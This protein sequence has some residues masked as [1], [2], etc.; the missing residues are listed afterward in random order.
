MSIRSSRGLASALALFALALA[1]SA[2]RASR[3]ADRVRGPG[4]RGRQSRGRRT[5]DGHRPGPPHDRLLEPRGARPTSTATAWSR[6]LTSAPTTATRS[7]SG[8]RATAARPG[9]ATTWRPSRAPIRGKSQGFSDPDLTLD[10]GARIY[11]TGINLANDSLF[12]SKD[13][14]QARSTRAR[15]SVTT[16]IARGWPAGS[17]TRCSWPRNTGESGHAVFRRT[18]T[19][20]T[21]AERHG[22]GRRG[23]PARRHQLHRRRQDLLRP[24]A[25]GKLVE[26]VLFTKGSDLVGGSAWGPRKPGDAKFVPVQAAPLPSGMFAHWPSMAIDAADNLYM[27]WDTNERAPSGAG[28]CGSLPPPGPDDGPAPLPNS[29]QL[30]VSKDFGR[31]W[32]VPVTVA[33]PAGTTG[34]LALDRRRHR[35]HGCR[36]S[37][38]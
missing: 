23:R 37:G 20:A 11:D 7:T 24:P 33:R 28:G 18:P 35:R 29:I 34:L 9:S 8:R 30:A 38:T 12:S 25:A 5:A 16:A 36:S 4:V 17:A 21:R 13:G 26:P 15:P 27:V 32:S 6:R 31:T 3:A 10:E 22:H 1:P 2:A 14:G 19:A